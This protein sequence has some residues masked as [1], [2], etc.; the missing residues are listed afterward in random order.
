MDVVKD[1]LEKNP[2]FKI[3][4]ASKFVNKELINTDGCI[5]TFPHKHGIDGS[6]AARLVKVQ[7]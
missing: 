5:E 6:F 7:A 4:D 3:D 2:D 1:F